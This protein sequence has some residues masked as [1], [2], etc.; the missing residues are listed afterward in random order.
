MASWTPVRSATLSLLLDEVVGTAEMVKTRQEYCRLDDCLKSSIKTT[1]VYYTGSKAEGLDLPGSDDDYMLDIN[2]MC[3]IEVMQTEQNTHGSSSQ[4]I[5]HVCTKNV[6]PGF[7]ILRL[8]KHCHDPLLLRVSRGINGVPHL[9][10]FL[11]MQERLQNEDQT[12]ARVAIQGPS[13]ERWNEYDVRSEPGTDNVP[14]IY[15]PFWPSG[16]EEWIQRPR[17]YG[18]P[19]SH[20]ITY[21]T[22]FGCHLVPVGHP[23]SPRREMEWRISFS[24]AERTLVWAFNH[25]QMQCYAVLKTILKEFIKVNCSPQNYVLCS[26]FI[27]TFLFWKFENT[28]TTFWRAENFKDCIICLLIEFRQC[29]REGLMRHYFFPRFNLLSIKLTRDAQK[30]LLQ[31]FGTIIQCDISVFRECSALRK[32]WSRFITIEGQVAISNMRNNSKVRN[33]ECFM[34]YAE[35]V[36]CLI[37]TYRTAKTVPQTLTSLYEMPLASLALRYYSWISNISS[38]QPFMRN[39]DLYKLH[40]LAITDIS[41]FDISTSKLWYAMVLLMKEDYSA[42]LRVVNDVL[43]RSPPY[44]LYMSA[45]EVQSSNESMSLYGQVYAE[46]DTDID[47]IEKVRTSWLMDLRLTTNM[48]GNVPCAIR[49]E[50]SVCDS[51]IGVVIS[52]FTFAYYLMFLCYHELRQYGDRER[53]LRLLIDVVN[54]PEQNGADCYHSFNIAGHCLLLAGQRDRARELFIRSFQS[55]QCNAYDKYNSALYYLHKIMLLEIVSMV[56]CF[57]VYM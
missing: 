38:L 37:I 40:R 20:D 57:R 12:N 24:V 52:P 28:E 47:I 9:S 43:S 34:R 49:V 5:L 42:C 11:F 51:G 36:I 17:H 25:V 4:N 6:P 48:F 30:E 23:L 31:L 54:N 21:I 1:A 45:G 2:D 27:K 26:Y 55:T 16:A 53:A 22:N 32:V 33:D 39:S 56:R 8:D 46:S 35:R 41:S 18:W 13:I 15:C 14:S 44:T 29:I 7:A 19:T 3:N 50:L 10:S